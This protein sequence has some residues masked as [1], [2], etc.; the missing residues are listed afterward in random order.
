M[1]I[2]HSLSGCYY[3]LNPFSTDPSAFVDL[4]IFATMTNGIFKEMS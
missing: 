1:G 4:V 3:F 2:D